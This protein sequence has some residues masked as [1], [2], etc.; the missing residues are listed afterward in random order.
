MSIVPTWPGKAEAEA[1]DYTLHSYAADRSSATYIKIGQ[2]AVLNLT[3]N[4]KHGYEEFRLTRIIGVVECAVG[5]FQMPNKN[6]PMFEQQLLA[7]L[8]LQP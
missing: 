8:R 4:T 1:N 6:F 7:L 5:P 3:C 2:E